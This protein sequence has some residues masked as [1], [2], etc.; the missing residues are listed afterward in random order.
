MN[1]LTAELRASKPWPFP[2]THRLFCLAVLDY[3]RWVWAYRLVKETPRMY[4]ER[5]K[6]DPD[7]NMGEHRFGVRCFFRSRSPRRG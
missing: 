6:A 2:E 3:M 4:R 5:Q 1:E 7:V